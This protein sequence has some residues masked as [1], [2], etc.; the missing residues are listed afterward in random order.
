[1][2]E[3]GYAGEGGRISGE[4]GVAL[5]VNKAYSRTPC[6]YGKSGDDM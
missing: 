4:Q 6:V 5:Y 3:T 1:M 2:A